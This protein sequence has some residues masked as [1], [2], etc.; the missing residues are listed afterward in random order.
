M[1]KLY[2]V[3]GS[4]RDRLLGLS[5]KD[6]DFAVE[7]DSWEEMLAWAEKNLEK[8]FLVK[9]EFLT[10]RGLHRQHGAVDFVMCRKDGAYSDARRP[11]EVIPGTIL[12]DLARRDFTVNAMAINPEGL[13]VDPHGGQRDL[14][15]RLLRCVGDCNARMKEDS[16]RVLRAIRFSVVKGFEFED[17]LYRYLRDHGALDLS[18]PSLSVDR[19]REELNL[20]FRADS[21]KSFELLHRFGMLRAIQRRGIWF[22]PTQEKR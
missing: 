9:P 12:D 13:I 19:I 15:A 5:S 8:V 21:L 4:V 1:I 14:E 22:L 10:V 7:A 16:L 11:D 20:M 2:E 3:G 6:R 18:K 17:E